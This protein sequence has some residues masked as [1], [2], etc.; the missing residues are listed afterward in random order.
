MQHYQMLNNKLNNMKNVRTVNLS[1]TM[2]ATPD[3]Q[4][5]REIKSSDETCHRHQHTTDHQLQHNRALFVASHV[6]P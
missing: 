5:V 1:M 2:R 3:K 6:E 4:I